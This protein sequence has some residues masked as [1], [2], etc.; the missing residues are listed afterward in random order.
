MDCLLPLW[1][2]PYPEIIVVKMG[3]FYI[4][5]S[6]NSQCTVVHIKVPLPDQLQKQNRQLQGRQAQLPWGD[7]HLP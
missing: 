3:M 7:S 5:K 4:E 2:L 6:F 1:S